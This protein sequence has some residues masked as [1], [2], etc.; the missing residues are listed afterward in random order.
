MKKLIY[1]LLIG[2]SFFCLSTYAA[3]FAP[4]D[5]KKF[6]ITNEC[7]NC[8]LTQ[9]DFR[10]ETHNNANLAGS[11]MVNAQLDNA[12]F[13]QAN[14]HGVNFQ[15]V[16]ASHLEARNCNFTHAIL[17]NSDLSESFLSNCDFSDADLNNVNFSH[18]NLYKTK[19]S[20][21]QLKQTNNLTCAILP[22]GKVYDKNNGNCF[23]FVENSYAEANI[24]HF[25]ETNEC[26]NCDLSK[27]QL[28]RIIYPDNANLQ[29]AL[30]AMSRLNGS[31]FNQGNFQ[32][33]NLE[34][35]DA[36]KLM[37]RYS[38]FTNADLKKANFSSA[39]LGGC[40]FTN[41]NLE[42]VIFYHANLYKAKISDDQL[43]QIAD[44]D[45]AIMPDGKMHSGRYC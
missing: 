12:H 39:N 42:D 2:S 38:N 43:K 9:S 20:N 23:S 5:E 40:D 25:V 19:I 32:N 1:S 8:D 22:D 10:S 37:A 17:S 41:A 30:L 31:Q 21:D 4:E 16:H 27:V 26:I 35:V 14:F 29:G 44:L 45:C 36:S 24:Q 3:S 6:N 7:L 28:Y 33:A 18:A 11:L 15:Y 13:N 34:Y